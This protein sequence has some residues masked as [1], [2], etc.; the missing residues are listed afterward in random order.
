MPPAFIVESF[1]VALLFFNKVIKYK[2]IMMLCFVIS[3]TH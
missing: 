1:V 3:Y 2:N